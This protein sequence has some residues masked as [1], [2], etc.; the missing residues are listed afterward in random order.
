MKRTRRSTIKWERENN[1][2]QGQT[3]QHNL[4]TQ[5]RN[6]TTHNTK[7]VFLLELKGVCGQI[8]LA[9]SAPLPHIEVIPKHTD[10]A[11]TRR[12][13]EVAG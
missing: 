11:A 4:R 3:Q 12:E 5:H 7:G 2:G 8:L 13:G 6:S 9:L 1:T 10:G